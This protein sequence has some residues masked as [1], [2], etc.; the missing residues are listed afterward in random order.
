MP[1]PKSVASECL[2]AWTTGDF[3]KARSMLHDGLSAGALRTLEAAEAYLDG[4]KGLGG[5]IKSARQ[6]RGL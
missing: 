6:H 4:L 5:V 2:R 3:E 1:D